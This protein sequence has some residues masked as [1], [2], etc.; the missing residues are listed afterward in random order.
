MSGPVKNRVGT[1]VRGNEYPGFVI[2]MSAFTC[3]DMNYIVLIS[4]QI[5]RSL[6]GNI[7]F[8]LLYYVLV[9]YNYIKLY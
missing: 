9:S 3:I 2:N 1:N 7:I 8:P 4:C 5:I 6:P